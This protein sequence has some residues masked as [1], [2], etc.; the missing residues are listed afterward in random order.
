[1]VEQDFLICQ[2]VAA[3]FEDKFL[4]SQVAMRGGTVLHKAHLGTAPRPALPS[5]FQGLPPRQCP[6][7]TASIAIAAKTGLARASGVRRARS[8]ATR[9]PPIGRSRFLAA[10]MRLRPPLS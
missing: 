2:A 1:M 8:A 4:K 6:D 9:L 10:K 5:R 7:G 3:I